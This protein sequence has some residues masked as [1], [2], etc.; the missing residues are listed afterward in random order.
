MVSSL[1]RIFLCRLLSCN[2]TISCE[3]SKRTSLSVGVIKT[4]RLAVVVVVVALA[5]LLMLCLCPFRYIEDLKNHAVN[6]LSAYC[7]RS[8][9]QMLFLRTT[10]YPELLNFFFFF[11][12]KWIDVNNQRSVGLWGS[13]F[14]FS[15][16]PGKYRLSGAV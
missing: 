14:F 9:H 7:A 1:I 3:K 5:Q 4:N 11:F 13:D 2:W 12:P 8:D 6:N 16:L 15:V 10:F